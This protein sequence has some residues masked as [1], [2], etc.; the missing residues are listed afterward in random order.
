[1]PELLREIEAFLD[2][3]DMERTPFGLA[4]CGNAKIIPQLEAGSTPRRRTLRKIR[5]FMAAKDA[6][7]ASGGPAP[8]GDNQGAQLGG[9]D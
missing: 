3:H 9:R 2:R 8:A 4:S 7:L 6:E 1:M 5:D